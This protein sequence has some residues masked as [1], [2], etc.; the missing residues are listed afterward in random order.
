MYFY[1]ILQFPLPQARPDIVSYSA[2]L[3]G[4]EKGKQWE[5]ALSLLVEMREQGLPLETIAFSAAISACEGA[6]RWDFAIWL[7][8]E[9]VLDSAAPNSVTYTSAIGSC[10]RAAQWTW[11]ILLL[12][13][14]SWRQLEVGAVALSSAIAACEATAPSATAAPQLLAKLSA[15]GLMASKC[16]AAAATDALP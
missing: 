5:K 15:D 16:W 6:R 14:M 9:M 11:A 10:A 12:D 13:E 8:E 2:A 4:C 1:V 3:S 7:L